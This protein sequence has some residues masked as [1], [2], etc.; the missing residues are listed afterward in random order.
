MPKVFCPACTKRTAVKNVGLKVLSLLVCPACH[1][2]LEVAGER[3]LRV[4][5]L[6]Q[7]REGHDQKTTTDTPSLTDFSREIS[8]RLSPCWQRRWNRCELKRQ[9]S[10]PRRPQRNRRA[11]VAGS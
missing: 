6:E 10:L 1:S 5:A 3:P 11:V 9:R 8:V 4:L 7:E 2:L